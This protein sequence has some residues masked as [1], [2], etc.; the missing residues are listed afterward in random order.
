MKYKNIDQLKASGLEIGIILDGTVVFDQ[1]RKE[2]V[3]VDESGEAIS[4]QEILSSMIGKR[5]RYTT[6]TFE[7]LDSLEKM[8]VNKEDL[9]N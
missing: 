6:V 3:I 8:L 2:H 9:L 7:T 1:D 5:I 4:I